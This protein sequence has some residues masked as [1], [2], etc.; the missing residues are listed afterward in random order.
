MLL[1]IGA[2]ETPYDVTHVLEPAN[3]QAR[4]DKG[5]IA[6]SRP[7]T[8]AANHYTSQTIIVYTIQ[9]CAAPL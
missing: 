6:M 4:M 8:A 3:R 2:L 9:A 7:I 1:P 5:Q